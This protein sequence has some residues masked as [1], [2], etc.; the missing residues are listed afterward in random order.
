MSFRQPDQATLSPWMVE[1]SRT[2]TSPL[3]QD[4]TVDV[5]IVGAGIAGM[6]TAY[7]LAQEGVSVMV[8]DDGVVGGGQTQ[9]TTAHLSNALDDRYIELEKIHGAE[10]ARL[11]AESHSRAIDTIERIVNAEEIACQFQRLD[12]YLFTPPGADTDILKQEGEAARRAGLSGVKLV[13]RVPWRNFDTGRA[14]FFPDQGQFQPLEYLTGLARAL[15]ARG[16][17]ICEATHVSRI[18]GGNPTV[19]IETEAGPTVT[20]RACVV[21]TNTPIVD[22]LAIHTKQ[23]PYAT[24]AIAGT[25]PANSVER[26]LYWDTLE[27]YHYVRIQPGTP[28]GDLLI[29]GGE[30]H[31]SGQESDTAARWERLETWARE[32]FPQLGALEFRWSGMVMETIDGLAF[33]GPDPEGAE[34]VYIATGDSG[35]GMTHGTIAGALLT[36]LIQGR[37]NP[38]RQI[39]DPRRKPIWG[40]AWKEFLRENANVAQQYVRDW[41]GPGDVATVQEIAPGTGAIVREGLAKVAVYR[42]DEGLF[43]R[44]SAVCP[45]LGC[46]VHWNASEKTWDCPCHGSRFAACGEVLVG[47]ANV[48]L[49]EER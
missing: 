2:A 27:A 40:M 5:C 28:G 18:A 8:L 22:W 19:R 35:M 37:E 11:A 21:A 6:T 31:K 25:I 17:R 26:A 14:L 23:A 49:P 44:L 41:L 4:A 10:G 1:T 32:R 7:L 48:P 36:D 39:Y 46:I 30:D 43:H 42:D 12:G 34:N 9:R 3:M 38:Y 16:G 20:A 24:Y 47:P 13:S 45:H 15:T 33:I 29:V